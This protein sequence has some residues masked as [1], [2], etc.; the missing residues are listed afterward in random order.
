MP[1]STIDARALAQGVLSHCTPLEPD[2][3]QVVRAGQFALLGSVPLTVDQLA[4]LVELSPERVLAVFAR[5]PGIARF[6]E[7]GRV[8]GLLG[9]STQRTPHNFEADGRRA[10]TWCAWDSLFIPRVIGLTARVASHCPFTGTP[11]RLVVGPDGVL[12]ASPPDLRVSFWVGCGPE[13]GQGVVA[14]CCPH[15]HFLGTAAA[16]ERWVSC[17][18]GG[19]VLAGDEAWEVARR[20]VD[21]VLFG[22]DRT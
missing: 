20:F 1:G 5:L 4:H 21:E 8:V 6:D 16:A 13:R 11:V 2:E 19:L 14:T 18:P 17:H 7:E 22:N 12:E 10:Y 15:I 9:L 3:Q